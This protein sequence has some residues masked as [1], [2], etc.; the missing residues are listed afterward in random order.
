MSK[1]WNLNFFQRRKDLPSKQASILL[2]RSS[3]RCI[4]YV[5]SC[6]QRKNSIT[7]PTLQRNPQSEEL[8]M[9]ARAPSADSG[10]PNVGQSIAKEVIT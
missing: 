2:R 3:S 6:D 9:Q 10:S 5:V 1:K 4:C 7:F 8:K